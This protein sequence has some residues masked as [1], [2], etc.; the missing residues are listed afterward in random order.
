MIAGHA[1]GQKQGRY[2]SDRRSDHRRLRMGH[3][4]APGGVVKAVLSSSPPPERPQI[5]SVARQAVRRLALV[6]GETARNSARRSVTA[7]EF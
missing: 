4:R 2:Y 1:T 3:S 7:S 5:L 6:P